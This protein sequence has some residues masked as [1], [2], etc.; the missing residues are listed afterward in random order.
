MKQQIWTAPVLDDLVFL[1]AVVALL[2]L[3]FLEN[4]VSRLI[5]VGVLALFLARALRKTTLTKR[6]ER[7]EPDQRD[8]RIEWHASAC[9]VVEDQAGG[10]TESRRSS[11]A[12]IHG[13]GASAEPAGLGR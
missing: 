13:A 1:V 4:D 2:A 8:R 3:P 9:C 5:L 6:A 12:R 7:C 11:S 10:D